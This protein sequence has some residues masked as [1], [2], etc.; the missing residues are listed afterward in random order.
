MTPRDPRSRAAVQQPSNE[1]ALVV[2]VPP[3]SPLIAPADAVVRMTRLVLGATGLAVD[4]VLALLEATVPGDHDA[5]G[6]GRAPPGPPM[7]PG[8]AIGL[9]L[10]AQRRS[11]R[12]ASV[13]SGHVTPA[14]AIAVRPLV[15]HGPLASAR[16]RI[17]LEDWS[18]RGLA[19]QRRNQ[20]AATS[21]LRALI[22]G[23]V[24]AVL[25]Q[26]DLN[27]VVARVDLDQVIERLDL[28]AIVARVDV[29]AILRRVDMAGVVEQVME[30]V[31]IAE[32]VR[33]SS[34][35]MATE[36]VD[37]LRVQ[38]MNADRMLGR[39]VDRVLRRGAERQTGPAPAPTAAL[40]PGEPQEPGELEEEEA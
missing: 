10:E 32:I 7:I 9:Y 13:L 24:T 17:G 4:A 21:F 18:M 33:E 6:A 3:A 27:S 1:R 28:D 36:T 11:L 25:E 8:A 34:S 38:G 22:G 2:V 40:P 29:Q 15:A 16:R 20:L 26:V 23:V 14:V 35:T 19:E 37:A 31:D 39:I 5:T 30:E 12:A